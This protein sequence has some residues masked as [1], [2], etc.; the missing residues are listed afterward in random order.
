MSLEL[1]GVLILV[2]LFALSGL[3]GLNLGI[4]A[5]VAT[6]LFGTVALGRSTKEILAGFP[7]ELFIVLLAVTFLF[8]IARV[9]GTVDLLVHHVMRL[10]GKRVAV[11]PWALFLI[12]AGLCAAGA[13]S[14]AAIAIVAPIG[15]TF[16]IRNGIKPLYAGLMAANGAAAGAFAPSG[17]LGGIVLASV[18]S[19]GLPVD[20]A[21]L[22]GGT[23][24]FNVAVALCS[25]VLFG[26]KR[27]PNPPRPTESAAEEATGGTAAGRPAGDLPAGATRSGTE[28]VAAPTATKVG[29][30]PDPDEPEDTR[31]TPERIATMLGVVLLVVGAALAGLDTGFTALTIATVLALAFPK[32]AARAV[33][34]I[35]WPVI[36]LVCGIV[37]YVSLLTALGVI[38]SLGAAIATIGAPLLAALV[39]CYTGG[40]VSAFASTTAILGA[41]IPLSMP[42]LTT[43]ALPVTAVL[44]AVCTASTIV[45]ASPFSTGGALIIASAPHEQRAR[46]YR[47]LLLWGAGVC[48][49]GP[50]AGWLLFVAL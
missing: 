2:V 31:M 4:L 22:F 45:D 39:I 36:L 47:G 48:A 5:F 10:A 28:V 29:A 27:D 23:F 35:A 11:I 8:G 43:G 17:I 13:A 34:E 24:A 42:F 38:D 33:S 6:F 44:I 21:L 20:R 49:I 9:N 15:I 1:I 3:R 32:T 14:P 16:A 18:E 37:T 30:R 50:A 40:V 12:T 26:R 7:G 46:T 25:W 41:L 19:Q